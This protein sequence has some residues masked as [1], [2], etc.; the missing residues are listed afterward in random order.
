MKK[1]LCLAALSATIA[2][3]TYAVYAPI[4]EQ[5]Q[6]KALSFR[7]GASVYYDSNVFGGPT[8]EIESMVYNISPA[9]L[10]NSSVTNQTFVS[11]SYKL[12]LDRIPDR[13]GAKTLT[14][15]FLSA[16]LAHKAS[17]AT[18]VDFSD[19]Y[20]ITKN[21]QSLLAG[22]PLNTNQS[23]KSNS[24]DARLTTAAGAKT[25]VTLKYRNLDFNYDGAGL[26]STLDRMEQLAGLE[27]S[28]AL[29]PETKLVGEYRYQDISYDRNGANKDKRSNFALVGFDYSP[30]AKTTL[31]GR[32]GFERRQREGASNTT[33]PYAELTSRY[34]YADGSY[35]AA[36]Y[37]YR[38][39]EPSDTIRY[40][41]VQVNRLFVNVQ[42]RISALLT[43]SGSIDYE[44]SQLQG[45]PGVRADVRETITRFGAGLSWLPDKN[46]I[47]SATF[48]V[49]RVSSD[50]PNREQD[51]KR[52]GISARL[53][54]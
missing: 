42:H 29:L 18:T 50:D 23:L 17:E 39:E 20:Q 36:G 7:L 54:F 37:T 21:P 5:E 19:T 32:A 8:R 16:R 41:D 25:G 11:A 51:R 44:P 13:P 48:D 53:T 43:A 35:L 12:S 28:F 34:A 14:S 15:H 4:P 1:P 22:L 33:A 10:F 40:T 26:S 38:F 47:I 24:L 45:R 9:I 6:G 49:D 3:A 46:W 2:T 52:A 27:L 30:G 31:S